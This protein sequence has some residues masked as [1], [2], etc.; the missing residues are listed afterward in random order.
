ML[1]IAI[2]ANEANVANR[3]GSNV[4]A[5]QLLKQLAALSAKRKNVDFTILLANPKLPDLPPARENWRYML[6]QPSKLWTQWALPI[7]LFLHRHDYDFFFTPG[8]YAPRFSA[9]PYMSSVM[10][11][12]YLHFPEQFRTQ[13]LWQLKKW[14]AYSVQHA[15]KILTISQFSKKEIMRHYHRA[16]KDI[17]VAYPAAQLAPAA[18]DREI[19]QFFHL[20]HIQKPY[21]LYLGTLQPRKNILTL[22]AA[23]EKFQRQLA[24]KNQELRRKKRTEINTPQLVIAGKLGWLTEPII[25]RCHASAFS[26]D[27]ILT[28]FVA[29]NLKR[30]LYQHA[31]ASFLL[32]LYEGFGIPPLE[33]MQAHCIPVV[34]NNSSLPEVVGHNGYLVEAHNETEIAQ[35]LFELLQLSHKEKEKIDKSMQ[36][37][38]NRFSWQRSAEIL[39]QELES[40]ANRAQQRRHG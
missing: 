39:W 17:V 13:D 35:T 2:D 11:L 30:P 38:V 16:A 25:E 23:F 14:T 5:Y 20:H 18:S 29:E 31:V 9:V 28:G 10:D 22:I 21:F 7:H 15:Q 12:A 26:Q 1:K 8:H 40:L 37:Q 3:V 6:I 24:A 33:S 27:I 19:K 36:K 4:Y 34:S 32:S